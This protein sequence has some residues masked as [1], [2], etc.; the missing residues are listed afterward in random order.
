MNHQNRDE[1]ALRRLLDI[2]T[3]LRAENG[4]PW[5]REQ[6]HKSLRKYV[7]EEA[8]EVVDA[9]N[10]ENDDLVVE[11]LGDLLL[12]IVFHAQLGKEEGRYT[13]ADIADGIS[14]K[15]IRRHPH[16]FGTEH[17]DTADS[18]LVTWEEVKAKEKAG[19]P[20][21]HCMMDVPLTFPALY[22]GQKIQKKAAEA[23]FDWD[24]SDDV[25]QKILEEM[26][27]VD[28]A[29]A[30]KD[31]GH[32]EEEMGDLLF[33]VVNWCRFH[34]VDAEEALRDSNEKFI[35]R[36][37]CMKDLIASC[38]KSLEDMS[39]SEMDEYWERAKKALRS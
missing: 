39:L 12:Q 35:K 3:A 2:M 17:C 6:D 7:L 16:V 10:Q 29:I 27:E 13:F 22:R 21:K 32:L 28:E 31:K 25:R 20:K 38:G 23:G 15:M 14:D 26:M 4:C 36:F 1:K 8:Y 37:H 11:E 19:Q 9:I 34:H 33:S 18:V 30:Q 5:D 24:N